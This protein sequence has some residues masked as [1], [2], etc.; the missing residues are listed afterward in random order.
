M[1]K[2]ETFIFSF[3]DS[4]GVGVDVVYLMTSDIEIIQETELRCR[5]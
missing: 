1:E 3:D 2:F 5:R 4:G